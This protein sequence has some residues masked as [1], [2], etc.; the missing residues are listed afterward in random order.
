MTDGPA[1]RPDPIETQPTET[2]S[3]ETTRPTEALPGEVNP[4]PV[5]RRRR[6]WP[7]VLLAVFLV[8]AAVLTLTPRLLGGLILSQLGDDLQITSERNGGP[9][10]SPNL[11]GATVKLPGIEGKAG[12]VGVTVAGVNLASRTVKLNVAVRDATVNLKLQELLK[13]GAATGEGGWKVVLGSLD[14]QNARVNVDGKGVNI[15]NGNFRVQQG[16]NG[17]LAVRGRTTEGELNADVQVSQGKA[18][19]IFGLDLDADARVLNHYWPGVTAGRIAGRY[20][21]NDGPIRGDLRVVDA[22]LRVPGAK[23]VT[24]TGIDGTATH[25]GDKIDLKLA[26][27]G[28]NGPV[29]AV[30]AIDLKAQNW[31]V[32]A[33]ADPTVAGLAEALGTTGTGNLNLRVT[34]GGWSTVR[35]KAY[36]KGAG[37]VAGVPFRDANVEYTLLTKDG[38]RAG[39]TNDL[40]FSVKTALA[41]NQAITGRWALGRAGTAQALGTLAGQPLTLAAKID[42]KNLLTLGGTALGGPA[43]GSFD[44]KTQAIDAVLNPNVSGVGARVALTGKPSDVRAAISGGTVGPFEL[45][46]TARLNAQGLTADLQSGEGTAAGTLALKLDREF[47]GTWSAQNLSGAGVTLGGN[48]QLDA[49]GGDLTGTITAR[50]PGLT[51]P[52]SGPLNLNYVRQRGT[53]AP[54]DQRLTWNG[55]TFGLTARNLAVAGGVTVNGNLNVTTALKATGNLSAR[56]NGFDVTATARGDTASLRGVLGAAGNRVTV[57]ADTQLSAGFLTSARIE[58]ADIEGTVSVQDGLRFSLTT[59]DASGRRDTARGVIDGSNWD[60]TGRVNLAALRPLLPALAEQ[61]LDGTLDLALAGLGGTARLNT[62]A[63]GAGVSGILQR[64]GQAIT[65]DLNVTYPSVTAKLAGRV[66]P[67]VQVSGSG[68]YSNGTDAPQTLNAVLAGEYGNLNARLTG[69][70][71]P[72]SFSGVTIPA[73]AVN[74][75][76]TVTPNMTAAGTWGDLNVTYDARTGLARVT[77]RQTL[78]AFGQTGTVQGRATWGPG[79]STDS[80]GGNSFRGA[81]EASGVLDQYTVALSGPWD[82][83]NVR[84]SDGEGLRA[85]G[86]ASLPSGRYDVD[87]RGPIAGGTAA[88]G[89]FIDGNV[90]GT[91]TEPRGTVNVFDGAGGSARVSLR[92]F[93]DLDLRARGLTL[94]GQ[95]LYGDLSARNNVLSGVIDAG[96]FRLTAAGG[97]VRAVGEFVGQSVI[98]S[99]KLTL[100]ATVSDLNVRV[101]GPYLSASATGSVSDLRGTVRLNAQTFGPAQARVSIP[102]QVLPLTASLT[103]ARANIGGLTFLGGNWS[104]AANLRYLLATGAATTPGQLRLEGNGPQ[105]LAVPSGPVAGRVTVLPTI[106]GTLSASLSPA[107]PFLPQAVRKEIVPGRLVARISASG[108]TLTTTG[109]RYLNDPLN[110]SARVGW[111][112]G[113]TASGTLSHPGSRIPVRYDGRDLTLDAL[114]LNARALR[115][116]LPGLTGTLTASLTVPKLDFAQADGRARVNLALQGQRADGLVSLRRGQLG[117]DLTSTLAGLNLRVRGPLYPQADAVLNIDG[118]RGTLTGNADRTLNLKAVGEFQGQAIDLTASATNLTRAGQIKLAGNV[119]GQSISASGNLV[120]GVLSGLNLRVSG[121]YLSA[122]ASGNLADLRGL[123]RLNAQAFGPAEARVSLPAQVLPLTASVNTGRVNVG[124]LGY[125][126]GQWSGAANLRYGF[127]NTPGQLRLEGNGAQLLA[128]PSGPVAGRVTVLPTIGGTLS[129]SL[130]PAVP[131]LPQA[132]RKEFVA[133]RLIAQI[134]ATDATL[135]NNGTRY[136]GQPLGLAARVNWKNGLTA[137]GTVTHPGSR[138]PVRYDGRDLNIDGAVLDARVLQ[139]LLNGVTGT[140]SASLSVPK[141][142]FGQ[143]SGRAQVNLALQGQ[144]AVGAVTVQRGQVGADLTSTLAGLDVRVRGPLYPQ[145]NAVLNVDGVAGTL[146]G[147]AAE[148]LKLQAAG[149][150]EG[151]NLNLNASAT[152]LTTKAAL[153]QVAGTVAGVAVNVSLKQ[154]A[155]KWNT[156][157]SLDVPDLRTLTA[158][159]GSGGTA[160]NLSATIGGTL[161]NL[162]LN[163]VGEAA[164]VRFSAPATYRGGVLRLAGASAT[165]PDLVSVRA[166]GPVFPTLGLSAKATLTDYL[167]GTYTVQASGSLSKPDVNAQGTL[168]SAPTGLQAGGSRVTARLLGQDYRLTFVGEPL[169]GFV[170][171]QLG[172]KVQGQAVPGGLLDSRLTLNTSYIGADGLRVTL[173]G[174]TG[175]NARRGWLGTLQARGTLGENNALNATLNGSGPLNLAATLRTPFNGQPRT[176]SVTGSLP[177]DLPFR[178]GGTLN[179]AALDV[180]TLWGR[181]GQLALTGQAT[182]GGGTWSKLAAQFAGR[183]EDSAGELTGDLGATYRAGDVSVRLAGQ[184]ISGGAVLAGG[185]YDLTLRAEPLRLARLLPVNLDMDALTFGGTITAAGTLEGGPSKVT[186]RNLALKGEQGSIRDSGIGPFSLYGSASYVWQ[187]GGQNVLEAALDGSLRGGVLQAR[188][189]LPAGVRVTARDIDA[190]TLGAGVLGAALNLTGDLTNP[191]VSGQVN[192]V[193]DAFSARVILSGRALSLNANARANLKGSAQGTLYAEAKELNLTAGAAALERVRARVYGTVASGANSA[194]LDLNGVW[195]ALTGTATATLSGVAQP[196]SLTGDGRGGYALSGGELGAGTVTLTLTQGFIPALAGTLRLTPLPLVGGTG[197]ATAEVTLGGTLTAPTLAATVTTRNAA[198]SGVTL[199]DTTGSI[200]GTLSDLRGTLAQ[201]GATVATLSG[202]TVNLTGLTAWVAGATVKATGTAGLNGTADV[203]LVSSGALDGNLRATYRARALSL[204]GNL[205]TQGVTAALNLDADPFTGWHGTARLTGGPTGVLTQPAT[206]T[207]SG[208]LAHPLATGDAGILGAGAKIVASSTGVQVRLVDGPGATASGAVELRPNSAGQW[209]WLGATSL[210]RPELSLSVTPS[211]PLADPNL[212]LSLRRGEWRASG[213]ASLRAADLN[214]SDGLKAGRITWTDQT[215]RADLPGLDLS[216]LGVSLGGTALTGRVTAQGALS[217]AT[218]DGQLTLNIQDVT[219]DYEVPYLGLKV[220]G[221][222]QATVNLIA[223]KPTVQASATLPAGILTLNAQ[224][225]G[226]GQTANNWTGRLTGS[227]A[228]DGGTLALNVGADAAGLTGNV[229]VTRYPVSG[230]GQSVRVDGTVALGGQTFSANLTA[231]NDMGEARVIGSGGLADVVP[232]LSS[233]L[234]VRPTEQGYNLR[235]TLDAVELGKLGIAPALS[236]RVSGEANINDGGGTFVVRSAGLTLGPKTLPARIEGTQIGGDW[237]IRGFL[238]ESDLFGGLSGGELFGNVTLKS[239]PV[240]AIVGALVGNSPG[241][242]IVTGVARFRVPV[243]DPLAGTATVVAE[244]IRVSASSGTGA[245]RITETLLGS[246]TLDY[247]ARELRNVN[248]QLAGAGTWDVRGAFSRSNVGLT[249]QFTNTTFTPVLVLVPAIADLDPSLKGTLT[250]EVAGTYDRPR[251]QVRA[252]NLSGTLAGLSLQVPT[253]SGDLPDSGAFSAT[254]RV[255]TGGVVGSDGTLNASGQLTLGDLSQTRVRFEGLLAPQALGALPNTTVTLAQSATTGWTL[256]AQS[257]STNPVTGTGTLSLTG[258][259][260]PRWDLAL[261]ARNYNLPLA[262]I[263]ARESALN[264]DLRAVDDGSLIRVSGAADFLRLTL[265]RVGATATIPAPGQTT[266]EGGSG[267]NGRT[268][269]SYATPLPDIYSTFPEPGRDPNAPAPARPFLQRLVLEDIPVRAPN[270]IRVDEALARAEFGGSLVVSGTGAQP[271]ITGDI[272]S[273]RGSIFLR[274]NEFAIQSGLVSFT[275]QS[276]Y[277]T[278]AIVASGNVQASTTGQRVPVTLDVKG[279][280]RTLAS[281]ASTLDLTTALRCT[282]TAGAAGGTGSSECT[283]PATTQA[284]SEAQLYALVATGVPNLETLP[285]N[286]TALGASALQT[287]L[288]IFV[289]GEI[290]RNVARALGLDV[291]RL[292]PNLSTADGSLGATIT[293]GSYLTRNLY[294]QYQIDLT[295]A[296]LVD[297]TYSTPDK[298]FTFKVST[299]LNG[300]DLQSVRPSFSAA[301]NVN[302][303]ASVS[304]GV[305]NNPESTRLRFGVTYRIR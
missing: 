105:L 295:G 15:P 140:L 177:A 6:R 102:A 1:P 38:N 111:Q 270:G 127:G 70:T 28:W 282:P 211:G 160:G 91:G 238:G 90:T 45:A 122:N 189:Q 221:D 293:L 299:P 257:R 76:G 129:A 207:L 300:L 302:D 14:V 64:S 7:W 101:D 248:I 49:T 184:R 163:A 98:A 172:V 264:A 108:A 271:R 274:E 2:Q 202:Q 182:L 52:L 275:G 43:R 272:T 33:D 305:Q 119:A 198:L 145:A 242:G 156:A 69:R 215:V 66:F 51:A 99:G 188:G 277:P 54:A 209:Q 78:T 234:A 179:L 4:A 252:S 166:S 190:R 148:T 22:A 193:A 100:P 186:L 24:V 26:G 150:Y 245:T 164:G 32:T 58:G 136:V 65:A 9:L 267:A 114:V 223:G 37:Q 175:W 158:T 63:A 181:A 289:L 253:F 27:R 196:I 3:T 109:T 116:L 201:A 233:V 96:P 149:V 243:A 239:F 208:P 216:R 227:L 203:N 72:L 44:L 39:Q 284:Y 225:T 199:A 123:V 13:G 80:G 229:T 84:L 159:N 263:Y 235:A 154:T 247:A 121:P 31:S 249:A 254:G 237:R 250:L 195:P 21:L 79:R 83:L 125:A 180:G 255:L 297:A 144:R 110:L 146:T 303:R 86:K 210:T 204:D 168:Q 47:K 107:L 112:N 61:K 93:S 191:A 294:L 60:A 18:G 48:G 290:E 157:G 12:R 40:A 97:R 292:T 285:G 261:T 220:N 23:F 176:A 73:Q 19:N 134:S 62:S 236:G 92:G 224:Q 283:D 278:F 85:T 115:P 213:T 74:L 133:G 71:G 256:E 222:L 142:D 29:N 304:V 153:A 279:E 87:L 194:K 174:A 206:L 68:T 5:A 88:G 53:F 161:D 240:G 296:G 287:A 273:Q 130:S 280:F 124:G 197:A 269:D 165:L 138:I 147:S 276:L 103:G 94:G 57:L 30:G 55:D 178:P 141:L 246:G 120:S 11:S 135:T 126:G 185:K 17:K 67:N 192:T 244:R 113:V 288:N 139:P 34:A 128:V 268:T 20:V 183:I 36:A 187:P 106:G 8:L 155:G 56:G 152:G 169:A 298:Q 162:T 118:V 251:G 81:A 218:R 16:E 95:K 151:R 217:T 25:R 46:G 291:F 212:V 75:T 259:I 167:P 137:S 59:A 50:L 104:G 41:G 286:L 232:A 77:G 82:S 171:G 241:E 265:G 200:T 219:T 131:F 42:D 231:A 173:N 226:T 260:A 228:Q 262:V 214:I 301:Y 89:L 205:S 132:V 266:T 143:A 10:W 281:G 35:V 258:Q 170:R 230:A 117:A